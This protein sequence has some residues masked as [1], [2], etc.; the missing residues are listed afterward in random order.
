LL[1]EETAFA[2]DNPAMIRPAFTADEL[3]APALAD[4]VDQLDPYVSMTP[5]IV[6]EARKPCVQS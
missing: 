3:R 2:A 4:G 6:G 5:S 1:E